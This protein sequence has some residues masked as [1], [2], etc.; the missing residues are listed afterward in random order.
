MNPAIEQHE[1]RLRDLVVGLKSAALPPSCNGFA[2]VM[3]DSVVCLLEGAELQLHHRYGF[4][5]LQLVAVL[6]SVGAL[7]LTALEIAGMV[8]Q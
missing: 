8:L 3:R 4:G 1:R 6:G 2:V 7:C 5:W